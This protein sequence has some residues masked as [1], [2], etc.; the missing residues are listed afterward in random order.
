MRG[1]HGTLGHD[2][3]DHRFIPARA[4]EPRNLGA[5]P[6]GPP[7]YPRAC[8][9]TTPSRRRWW[10]QWALSPRVRGNH[11]A[12]FLLVNKP[13]S[14]PARAGEPGLRSMLERVGWV[15]PRACGGTD[16]TR[17]GCVVHDGLSPRVRG[18]R[19]VGP[20]RCACIGSIP[21]RAGEPRGYQDCDWSAWVYPRACGGTVQAY[22]IRYRPPGLSPRVRGNRGVVRVGQQGQRSIPACAGEPGLSSQICL[23]GA[24]YPRACGETEAALG[25]AALGCGLSPRVR[26]NRPHRRPR[27]SSLRSIPAR[28]GKPMPTWRRSTR[29]GVYPR[30]CGETRLHLFSLAWREFSRQASNAGT[31]SASNSGRRLRVLYSARRVILSSRATATL[32]TRPPRS[33]TAA[34][35]C[36]T[37]SPA[38]LISPP[39]AGLSPRVR[40]NRE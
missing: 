38:L 40:G 9:G 6:P 34:A 17:E 36:S 24:V 15:Y 29:T 10:R 4:G 21:A 32:V 7:V 8:G 19:P 28:A 35:A 2:P 3:Q 25:Y 26:G 33:R 37:R 31:N 39:D 5:R 16:A 1:N 30:A 27:P 20:P 11:F 12:L 23:V 22:A 18:N 13:G 14:I